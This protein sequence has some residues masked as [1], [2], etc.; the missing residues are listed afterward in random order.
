[1]TAKLVL[2]VNMCNTFEMKPMTCVYRKNLI[3][4]SYK[5]SKRCKYYQN[6]YGATEIKRRELFP[7]STV[8]L[9]KLI[10]TH[11]VKKF[12]ACH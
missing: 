1:M 10:V 4:F 9:E 11:L 2:C 7:Q 5:Y 12:P 6:Q 8:L 3:L